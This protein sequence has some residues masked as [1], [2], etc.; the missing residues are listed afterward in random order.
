M[1]GRGNVGG[2]TNI[3]LN[4]LAHQR[5][6]PNFRGVFMRDTLPPRIYSLNECGIVNLDDNHGSGTHWVAYVKHGI[7]VKYFDSFGN[8]RP[9]RE[10]IDYF[11][12][13]ARITYNYTRLQNF[14]ET[15]C[16]ELCLK[17]L[18]KNAI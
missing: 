17:F 13:N 14:N 2:T 6:I 3:E 7:D 18:Q 9:P 16:G 12:K 8:L 5:G 4:K 10:L 1:S 15:I 11:G